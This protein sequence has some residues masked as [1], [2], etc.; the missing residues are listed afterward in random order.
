MTLNT[1]TTPDYPMEELKR[2]A[3]IGSMGTTSVRSIPVIDFSDYENRRAQIADDLWNAA[4]QDG[5]FQVINHGIS[6]G[7]IDNC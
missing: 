4:T 1:K 2:E 6:L 7:D 5:F 3:T